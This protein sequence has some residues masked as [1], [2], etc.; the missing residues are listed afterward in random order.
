MDTEKDVL[1]KNMNDFVKVTEK[2]LK[3]SKKATD[4]NEKR[5]KRIED[6]MAKIR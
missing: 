4:I 2:K 5:K 6:Y 1:L 3:N